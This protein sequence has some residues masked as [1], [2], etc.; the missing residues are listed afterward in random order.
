[1]EENP[2]K[3]FYKIKNYKDIGWKKDELYK[4]KVDKDEVRRKQEELHEAM[5]QIR[6]V[7]LSTPGFIDRLLESPATNDRT[8]ESYLKLLGITSSQL[9]KR[10][11]DIGSGDTQKFAAGAPIGTEVVSLNP[12]LKDPKMRKKVKEATSSVAAEVQHL[13]FKNSS[14]DTIVS[15]FA[16]PMY[17]ERE[18]YRKSLQEIHR[19]LKPGGKAV[20]FPVIFQDDVEI[21]KSVLMD[22]G[23][24]WETESVTLDALKGEIFFHYKSLA[25]SYLTRLIISK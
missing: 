1:M 7:A 13:P 14:F 20:L 10:V 6:V 17:L 3:G 9:G 22:S 25:L 21:C 5:R 24:T 23:I 19:I 11:L 15:V 4:I 12:L 16:V 8:F 18:D 2:E